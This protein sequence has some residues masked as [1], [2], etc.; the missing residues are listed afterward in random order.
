M[1][2]ICEEGEIVT[3]DVMSGSHCNAVIVRAEPAVSE[4]HS[5]KKIVGG[6]VSAGRFIIV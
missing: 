3:V 2:S 1:T 5:F 4:S 6:V